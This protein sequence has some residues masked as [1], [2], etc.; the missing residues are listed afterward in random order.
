MRYKIKKG[1]HFANLT[2][3][4]LFPFVGKT[5]SGTVK[6]SKECLVKGEISGWNKLTGIGAPDNHADSGRLVWR[7][8]GTKI[9]IAGYVYYGG[10]R[11]E[12][13]MGRIDVET[14]YEYIVHLDSGRWYF[15]IDMLT[16]NMDGRLGLI[17]LRQY[18]YFGGK[19]TAPVTMTI[20][21]GK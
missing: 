6:F 1:K 18:P 2:I 11:T 20:T 21:L 9:E 13:V 7:A 10:M 12:K 4:R 17:K 16:F 14:E 15:S 5:I 8:I 3:N 19:S